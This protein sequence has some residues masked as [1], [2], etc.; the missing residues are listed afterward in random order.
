MTIIPKYFYKK[1]FAG[2]LLQKEI[3]HLS[4]IKNS[5]VNPFTAIIGGSKISTKI[6]LI[7]KLIIL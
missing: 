7:E 4:K 2:F 5:P 6:K 3:N 1:K